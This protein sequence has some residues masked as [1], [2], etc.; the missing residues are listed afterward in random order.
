[1]N[2]IEK[3]HIENY[4]Y[5]DIRNILEIDNTTLYTYAFYTI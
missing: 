2:M 5:Y 3:K 4:K 1:M